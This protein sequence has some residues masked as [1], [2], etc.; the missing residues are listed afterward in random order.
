MIVLIVLYVL[1]AVSLLL[2]VIAVAALAVLLYSIPR[3][4]PYAATDNVT[5]PLMLT[6]AKLK[7]GEKAIDIGSGDGKVVIALAKR[8]V[9]AHGIEFNP[10]LVWWS[11][12]RIRRLGL[13]KY[14]IIHWGD[15]WRHDY[16]AYD[17]ITIYGIFY[18]MK[19][20]EKKLRREAKPGARIVTNYFAFPTWKPLKKKGRAA[21]YMK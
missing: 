21:L 12:M 7:K 18:I 5:L 8:G 14:A 6:T 2:L 3:G 17:V 20:M 15:M 11:R 4:A 10:V 9:E 13:Q 1:L 19:R 16:S